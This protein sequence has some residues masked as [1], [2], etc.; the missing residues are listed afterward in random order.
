MTNL[1]K[2]MWNHAFQPL[3][4]SSLHYRSDSR[5][6]IWQYGDRFDHVLL[7]NYVAN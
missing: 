6:Q 1:S 2:G 4:K 7:Q 3:K 5:H